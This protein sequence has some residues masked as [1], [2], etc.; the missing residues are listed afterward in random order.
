MAFAPVGDTAGTRSCQNHRRDFSSNWAVVSPVQ[1]GIVQ[2]G[3]MG[4]EIGAQLDDALWASEGRSPA[5]AQRAADAGMIDCGRLGALVERADIVI[6]VC[7]PHAA[8]TV[9]SEVCRLGFDGIYVDANAI[10]PA[11]TRRI[12][13]LFEHF[14]DGGIIGPPP[15]AAG[16][17]RLYLS[18]PE[19]AAASAALS[20]G[21]L[22]APVLDDAVGSASALKMAYAAWTKGSAALLV[23]VHALAAA[24]GVTDALKREWA[25]SQ[26]DL[27]D[28][29]TR[30]ANV[31]GPRAWRWA[32][33][34]D[35]IAATFDESDLPAGFHRA[36]ADLYRQLRD[37]K[38]VDEVSIAALVAALVGPPT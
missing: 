34:M 7:P 5:T 1:I 27:I 3:Q 19:A 23:N 18:G 2:P 31:V 17:T 6:S 11:T 9:A 26:P 24:E 14:V 20:V 29:S 22:A 32:G 35:E 4:A 10:A 8:L 25:L 36:A 30:V 21:N 28:R 16:T 12:A 33:E 38:D 13:Q 15:K 37:F